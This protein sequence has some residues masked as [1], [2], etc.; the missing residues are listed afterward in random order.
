MDVEQQKLR[1][2]LEQTDIAFDECKNHPNSEVYALAYENAKDALEH[3]I[4]EMHFG[5]KDRYK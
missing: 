3:F 2:L 4:N 1:N 5:L